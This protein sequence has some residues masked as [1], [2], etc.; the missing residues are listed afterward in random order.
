MS[1]SLRRQFC[2]SLL[3]ALAGS[4]SIG[5]HHEQAPA[6]ETGGLQQPLTSF[7]ENLTSSATNL[8]FHP[9][10]EIKVP[11]RVQNPGTETWVSAGK[12]PVTVSYKWFKQADMLPIEGERTLLPKP[13]GPGQSVDVNV[14]V[15]APNQPGDYTVRITLVQEAVAWFMIQGGSFLQLNALVQ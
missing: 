10:Q 11:V 13:V 8:T 7:R 1:S 4:V 6:Q 14:R 3:I 12:F 2:V 5:C 15:V 9:G